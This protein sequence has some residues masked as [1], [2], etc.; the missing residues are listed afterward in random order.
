MITIAIDDNNNKNRLNIIMNNK[1]VVSAF[2]KLDNNDRRITKEY[3]AV[4]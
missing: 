4:E 1:K 3:D 2:N